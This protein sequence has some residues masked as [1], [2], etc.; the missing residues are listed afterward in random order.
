MRFF[1]IRQTSCPG[2]QFHSYPP[3]SVKEHPPQEPHGLSFRVPT[4]CQKGALPKGVP[5]SQSSQGHAQVSWS[6]ERC[7]LTQVVAQVQVEIYETALSLRHYCLHEL[8]G[9]AAF[10][11][12]VQ[13]FSKQVQVV[14]Q[15]EYFQGK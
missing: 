11:R 14:Y 9:T 13:S 4:T 1:K 12:D 6:H 10:S 3:P 8:S 5:F 2:T 7:A 15:I